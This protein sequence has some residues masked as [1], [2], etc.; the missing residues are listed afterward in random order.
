MNPPPNEPAASHTVFQ[1]ELPSL[2]HL[3]ETVPLNHLLYGVHL[4]FEGGEET[5]LVT[6]CDA[7]AEPVSQASASSE[8]PRPASPSNDDPLSEK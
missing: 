2:E 5:S 4:S 6:G 8:E 1:Q 3:L 7:G